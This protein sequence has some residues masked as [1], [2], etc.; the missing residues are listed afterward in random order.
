MAYSL[1]CKRPDP[2]RLAAKKDAREHPHI[3]ARLTGPALPPAADKLPP[4]VRVDQ[5]QT[6]S[7]VWGSFSVALYIVCLSF[8]FAEPTGSDLI[9]FIPSQR[10][11]YSA[12]RAFE[13]ANA[14]SPDDAVLPPLEDG[15]SDPEDAFQ[16]STEYGVVPMLEATTPDGRVYDI[17]ESNVNDEP[18]FED[19]EAG[20]RI[21]VN[22]AQHRIDP[23]D[24]MR[25]DLMAAALDASPPV[26]IEAAGMVDDD[27]MNLQAGD[28]AQP[29]KPNNGG[30]GHA[31][32]FSAY[33]T[34]AAG[35]R[36]FRLENSW[37]SGWADNGAVWCSEEFCANLWAIYP[38]YPE[39]VA[40]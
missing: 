20:K 37:G 9:K 25:S 14:A 17:D 35:K 31:F 12:T 32:A 18:Q 27:F 33:R 28:V 23:T 21:Q 16:I 8:D 39:K 19:L 26:A 34:N 4:W 15:G 38:L 6:A 13:R 1:G 7:C 29:A 30:G 22:A 5:G 40:A 36:E 10:E 3:K 11:G 2:V 24:P